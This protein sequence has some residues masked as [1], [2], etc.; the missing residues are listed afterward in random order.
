MA[1]SVT[2]L[3][4][5]FTLAHFGIPDI[6]SNGSPNG[7]TIEVDGMVRRPIKLTLDDLMRRPKRTIFSVHECAG[8]PL[9]PKQAVRAVAN[10]VWSG[11][12]LR[13]ILD[14]AGVDPAARFIWSYGVDRGAYENI[15]SDCYLKDMPLERLAE[16][17]VLLAY[18]MNGE[19]LTV[20]RGAP[21]RLFI[22]GYYGTNSVKWLRRITLAERRAEGPM[23]TVLYND[24][25]PCSRD[26]GGDAAPRP[27][28]EIA[29]ESVIVAPAPKAEIRAE[30]PFEIWGW[31]WAATGIA[32]VEVSTDDGATYNRANL[33]ARENWS[34]QRFSYG[35]R[36]VVAGP[37]ALVSRAT[38]SNGVTQPRL[39]ARNSLY[40]VAVNV[41]KIE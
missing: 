32:H 34:W 31:A 6:D 21:V 33:T 28:W 13:E 22:P 19:P 8:N 30:E 40:K 24:A 10:L 20:E 12:D 35:W 4:G 16:G 17:D 9:K 3:D 29:P 15:R 7:W 1:E 14:E 41:T 26:I 36:P 2:P 25:P 5:V 11:A 38:D 18:E 37:V 39:D 27:V 23:T